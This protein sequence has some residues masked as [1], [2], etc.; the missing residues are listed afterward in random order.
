MCLLFT[1]DYK[2]PFINMLGK[3]NPYSFST[4]DASL[5]LASSS[6]SPSSIHVT[7]G[8]VQIRNTDGYGNTLSWSF[9]KNGNIDIVLSLALPIRDANSSNLD[10][11]ASIIPGKTSP[12]AVSRA[13]FYLI[14]FWV[15]I[16]SISFK[17]ASLVS[18][19]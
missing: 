14:F 6:Q 11:L 5:R 19:K 1:A 9:H 18:T 8:M 10:A 15:L 3:K 4:K 16:I 13:W 7:A 2:H 17:I 12:S